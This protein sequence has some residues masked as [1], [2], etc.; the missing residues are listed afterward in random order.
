MKALSAGQ[1]APPPR[2]F[3]AS[4]A[5]RR[6]AGRH[7]GGCRGRA[8][9]RGLSCCPG[10]GPP[11]TPAGGGGGR[12]AQRC[13]GGP[14][15]PRLAPLPAGGPGEG[16]AGIVWDSAA[17]ERFTGGCRAEGAARAPCHSAALQPPGSPAAP[18][19]GLS[20]GW[21]GRR[22]AH[23]QFAPLTALPENRADLGR[24]NSSKQER[25]TQSVQSRL[26]FRGCS[27]K[28]TPFLR[29]LLEEYI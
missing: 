1:R 25:E 4:R 3:P 16:P 22:K 28:S 11:P 29:R 20:P 26:Y 17:A 14:W 19:A 2:P 24:P 21:G 18:P 15:R 5:L 13:H 12:W 6:G 27:V 7:R 8:P 10:P 23:T 9:R